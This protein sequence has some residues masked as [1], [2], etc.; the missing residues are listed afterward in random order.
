VKQEFGDGTFKKT[1]SKASS[2]ELQMYS[3]E[4]LAR[5]KKRE[6]I[7]DA[8]LLDGKSSRCDILGA[9]TQDSSIQRNSRTRSQTLAC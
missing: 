7:A 4:E 1:H 2:N 3:D 5:F 6:L 9:M 8:E